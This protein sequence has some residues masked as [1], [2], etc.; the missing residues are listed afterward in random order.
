MVASKLSNPAHGSLMPRLPP[1]ASSLPPR[2]PRIR[3]ELRHGC[4]QRAERIFQTVPAG[5]D[6]LTLETERLA[7]CI[8]SLGGCA[9]FVNL[10]PWLRRWRTCLTCPVAMRSFRFPSCQAGGQSPE[11]ERAFSSP[12]LPAFASSVPAGAAITTRSVSFGVA[13][14]G[15]PVGTAGCSPGRQPRENRRG[16]V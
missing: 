15:S 1:V 4:R 9:R 3:G 7:S 5:S 14:F 6:Q 8:S 16:P 10:S 11:A 13:H 12:T 2:K